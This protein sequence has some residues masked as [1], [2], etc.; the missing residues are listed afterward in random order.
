MEKNKIRMYVALGI[1]LVVYSVIAF[2]IP[3][4][5]NQTFAFSYLFAVI[6]ILLQLY[7]FH[8]SFRK[9]GTVRSKF[10]GFPIVRIGG[11]YLIGQLI[12]SLIEMLVAGKL[13]AW[14]ALVLNIVIAAIA[15]L[16]IIS[17][18]AMRNEIERQD[19]KLV[20][21]VENM[22]RLQSMANSLLAVC[23]DEE[24]KDSLKKLA[25]EFRYSDLVSSDATK[26]Y[27][28]ELMQMLQE[29]QVA[30]MEKDSN[31]AK[32]LYTRISLDLKE[33]NRLCALNK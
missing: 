28:E 3:F 31:S 25:E 12:L 14:I 16:G 29:L 4:E 24:I 10:Y 9:E 23:E 6:A 11:I 2:A 26:T 17:A 30:L 32:A 21:D 8:I 22:R 19:V 1:V 33:R 15:F 13:A 7:V 18:D 27:E 20:K 5:K